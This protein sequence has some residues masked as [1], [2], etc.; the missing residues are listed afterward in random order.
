MLYD[1]SKRRMLSIDFY[2]FGY[3]VSYYF[4]FY[5][6]I[7]CNDVMISEVREY[8]NT[9]YMYYSC[10]YLR[11]LPPFLS[12]HYIGK[13]FHSLPLYGSVGFPYILWLH[14]VCISCFV[15][16]YEGK[17]ASPYMNNETKNSIRIY[18]V[19]LWPIFRNHDSIRRC[20]TRE[21]YFSETKNE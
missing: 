8:G 6:S 4:F 14:S 18:G 20:C 16:E 3:L 9:E 12:W 17:T 10:S 5:R 15:Q 1:F 19:F 2:D 13:I 7:S 11:G 21:R